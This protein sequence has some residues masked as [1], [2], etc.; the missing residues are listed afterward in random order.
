MKQRIMDEINLV[1]FHFALPPEPF[2]I[3]FGNRT[4]PITTLKNCKVHVLQTVPD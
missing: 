4:K 3:L 2:Q 1:S